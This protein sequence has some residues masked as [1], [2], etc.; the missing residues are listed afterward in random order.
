[1]KKFIFLVFTLA[2]PFLAFNVLG[3]DEK[4]TKFEI[5]F[6]GGLSLPVGSFAKGNPTESAILDKN[7]SFTR[8]IGFSKKKNGFANSGFNYNMSIRYKIFP[9]LRL[10][11]LSSKFVNSVKSNSITNYLIQPYNKD[12]LFEESDY[13]ILIFTPGIAYVYTLNKID[14]SFN[15]YLGYS[16]AKYPYYKFILLYTMLDPP[17]IFGNVASSP[18]LHA[19]TFGSSISANYKITQNFEIGIDAIYYST[20]FPYHMSNGEVPGGSQVFEISDVL[21]VKV[22]NIGLRLSYSF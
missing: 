13:K 21:K 15:L 11:F 22:I 14:C 19:F 1:M 9:S 5:S 10:L 4:P 2:Q 12:Q 20:N 16:T 6:G 3:Q 18:D 17:P 8:I 7:V